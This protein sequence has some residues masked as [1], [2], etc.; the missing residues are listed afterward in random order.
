MPA[1]DPVGFAPADWLLAFLAAFFILAAFVWSPRLQRAVTALAE[2]TRRCML[3]LF[4]LPIALRLLLLPH[5]PVPTPEIYDE[6]SH[7]LAADTLLHGRLANP[8]HPLHQFFETFFELQQPTYSSIYPLGQGI[9]LALG[10]VVS[11]VPWTGVLLVT[12]AFCALCYWMLHAWV[13]PAWALLGGTLAVIEFGPL[14]QWMNSYWGGALAATAGCLVFG[15]LPR[16]REQWRS[17]DAVLLGIG[18]AM[19]MLTRQFESLL[20]FLAVALFL[21]PSFF[22]RQDWPGLLR[23]SSLALAA[24]L[25]VI[26]LILLQNKAVTH[27]WTMLPEQ[28][29][30]YQYGVPTSLTIE[31]NP[32]PHLPLTPQQELDYKAQALMHG[33][34]TDTLSKFLLRLEYRVRYCRF[35]FVPPLYIAL[36]AFFFALREKRLFWVAAALAIFALGTN[37]F[38]YLLVHYLAAVTCLFVLVSIIG[39]QQL[40]RLR[41]RGMHVG[42][43]IVR[44]LVLLCL[45]EFAVW[46]ALHL[47]ESPA[48]YPVLQYETWDS[49]NHNNPRRRIEV[50]SQLAAISGQLLVFVH[51]SPR[52]VYQDEWVWN[53]A[54]IDASRIVYARDLGA[55]NEKLIRY[56]PNR[57]ILLLEPDEDPPSISPVIRT[58]EQ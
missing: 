30:Q 3:L 22:R 14:S 8:P 43:E 58:G 24:V 36:I 26:A 40:G 48:A 6:F 54:D 45:A 2:R 37:L 21:A 7:L 9:V 47:F 18:F 11:G 13:T 16:L 33:S 41:I 27:S 52:H 51:Y 28:L 34:G 35:F 44:V 20:L 38:P 17:R 1:S 31:P 50:R 49:I 39:L 15:A 5:H 25:P 42:F 19:H 4:L 32:V 29:S 55:E 23:V 53:A 57:K 10:R 46:Y 12:G 56:F